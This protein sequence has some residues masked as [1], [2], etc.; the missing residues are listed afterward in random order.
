MRTMYVT[1]NIPRV[2]VTKALTAVRKDAVFSRVSPVRMAEL[3]DPPLPGR[4]WVRVRNRLAGICG[5]DLHVLFVDA[6]LDVAPVALPGNDP[7]YLGHEVVGEVV[8]VGPGVTSLKPG[9]RV[10]LQRE[11]ESCAT[12][13]IEPPCR[14]CAV[15]NYGV[16]EN[17]SLGRGP[18]RVGGGWGDSLVAH[19]AA[20]YRVPED[21]TDD[22][23]LLIEPAAI[24]VRAVLKRPPQPGETVLVIGCGTIGLLTVAVARAVAPQARIYVLARYDFQADEA[25]RL[26]ADEVLRERRAYQQVA[27]LTG[28]RLYKGFLGNQ[29]LLGGFDLVFDCVGSAQTITDGLRWCRAGGTLVLVGVALHR[30]KVDLTPAWYQEIQLLGTVYHGADQWEGERLPDFDIAVRLMGEGKLPAEGLITHRFA[31]SDYR[32][33]IRTATDKRHSGAIKV[34]F[35]CQA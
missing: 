18:Q 17:A 14:H 19:E 29:M 27:H 25:V 5:S 26:G 2:A 24:A 13:E 32:E 31:L 22:Q 20:F 8:E 1:V 15:G 6:D 33:G 16:C 10:V 34:A 21:L 4:R 9:D 28:A 12:Q 7:H 3:P 23:A 11:Q 35:D 30:L